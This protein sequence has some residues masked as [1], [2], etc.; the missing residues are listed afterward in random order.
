MWQFRKLNAINYISCNTSGISTHLSY[1]LFFC[2]EW[3]LLCYINSEAIIFNLKTICM[4]QSNLIAGLK[5]LLAL[6]FVA[7]FSSVAF[8]GGDKY[9]IYLNKK[10]MTE[11]FVKLSGLS[12]SAKKSRTLRGLPCHLKLNFQ[13]NS[14]KYFHMIQWF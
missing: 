1:R 4:K 5:A 11:Q 13:T 8:A 14:L 2:I 6:A 12:R 3:M 10:L 9:E 7:F